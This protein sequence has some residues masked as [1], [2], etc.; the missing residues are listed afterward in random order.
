[1]MVVIIADNAFVMMDFITIHNFPTLIFRSD[2][3]C[4]K[5]HIVRHGN[6]R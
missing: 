2:T 1:M 5:W 4:A 6:A 3:D